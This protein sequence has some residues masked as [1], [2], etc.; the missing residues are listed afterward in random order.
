MQYFDESDGKSAFKVFVGE[1]LVDRWI[2]DDHLPTTKP[3]AHSSTRH[4][5][6]GLALRPGDAIRIEAV[7][8]G[9]ENACVDYVEINPAGNSANR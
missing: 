1:Q 9:N 7:A 8:D 6:R 5:V 3:D 2:A 4:R